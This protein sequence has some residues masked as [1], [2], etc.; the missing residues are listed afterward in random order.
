[1]FSGI[2]SSQ[3]E[4]QKVERSSLKNSAK[5][6]CEWKEIFSLCEGES[7]ALDGICFT[8]ATASVREFSVDISS[9]TLEKTTAK[10]W[11]QGRKLN[12]EKALRLNDLVSG[13]LVTGHVDGVGKIISYNK[14]NEFTAVEIQLPRELMKYVISKGSIALNGVSLT[15]NKLYD[16]KVSFMLIPF[17]LEKT[18]LKYLKQG[19]LINIE[20]DLIGK[21]VA[22]F[23]GGIVS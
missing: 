7:V 16:N 9:E 13:H 3:V 17:T 2:I 5:L 10:Y 23:T 19:D 15:V 11:E 8:V 12:F 18:N 21:Y 6:W 20:T 22:S 14:E 1:M 4:I